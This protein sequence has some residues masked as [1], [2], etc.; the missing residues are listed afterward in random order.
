MWH[1]QRWFTFSKSCR[2]F[3]Y[4][5]S[6]LDW[7]VKIG[8]FTLL[9]QCRQV[10]SKGSSVAKMSQRV[11]ELHNTHIV[12]GDKTTHLPWVIY[13]DI[14]QWTHTFITASLCIVTHFYSKIWWVL[15]AP[16]LMLCEHFTK[17]ALWY[18]PTIFSHYFFLKFSLKRQM[19]IVWSS[20]SIRFSRGCS[21]VF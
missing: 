9:S 21:I 14:H 16:L 4:A 19:L 13:S 11:N 2:F 7:Q 17:T 3:F 20:F 15:A 12:L 1:Q 6:L 8:F 10:V 5:R 18:C